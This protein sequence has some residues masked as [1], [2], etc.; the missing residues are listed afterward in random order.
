[1]T[2]DIEAK[3]RERG[4]A[5]KIMQKF[6]VKLRAL[7]L[8]RK[9]Q[10]NWFAREA[11]QVAHFVHIHKFTFG[12]CFRVHLGIR[13]LNESRESIALNGPHASTKDMEYVDEAG[14]L[15]HCAEAMFRYVQEDGQHWFSSQDSETLARPDGW[16]D[17]HARDALE[18]MM[19]GHVI[20]Q[21]I[22][23]SR[24]LLGL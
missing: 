22:N 3:K 24:S 13:I 19:N 2:F 5:A 17:Q 4:N 18:Q 23:Q 1:M 14:S 10:S 21:N 6:A 11:N 12:P 15:E 9:K 20:E 16:L 8:S 7:D